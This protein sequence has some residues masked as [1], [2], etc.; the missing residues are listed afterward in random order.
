[1]RRYATD[2]CPMEEVLDALVVYDIFCEP[3]RDHREIYREVLMDRP[4]T[5]CPCDICRQLGYHVILFR[6]AERNRRRGFHNV[7]V[8]YRRLRR[9]LGLQIDDMGDLEVQDNMR[10]MDFAFNA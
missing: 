6:G 10:S 3:S 1:M 7:W 5:R 8:F 4:W 2:D 9:E